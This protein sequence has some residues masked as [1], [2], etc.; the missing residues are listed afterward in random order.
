MICKNCAHAFEGLYCYHCGQAASIRRITVKEILTDVVFSVIKINRGFLFTVRQLT[1]HPGM[2]I[3]DYLS[4]QRI[5]YYAPHKYLF[6][7]WSG[8]HLP[9]QPVSSFFE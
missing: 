3:R 4:G 9:D 1:F 2:A 8:C 7:Y 6:F 5:N